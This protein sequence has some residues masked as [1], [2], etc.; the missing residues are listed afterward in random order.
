MVDEVLAARGIVVSSETVRHGALTFGQGFAKQVRRRLSV[1]GD[2]FS[3]DQQ[4]RAASS[5][6][7]GVLR[8]AGG[9][10]PATPDRHCA[11]PDLAGRSSQGAGRAV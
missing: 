4:T 11:R 8:V 5:S 9:M 7:Q 6:W 3:G 10:G 2:D 1:S